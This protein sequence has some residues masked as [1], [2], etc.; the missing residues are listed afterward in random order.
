VPPA[1][2]PE[3]TPVKY[4]GIDVH[5]KMCQAAILDWNGE[6]LDETRFMNTVEGIEEFALK[7][8]A[9]RDEVRA[10]VESTGNLW[11]QVHDRLEEHGHDVALSSP[12]NS[13]L[14]SK[15]RV[16][17]D[18]TDARALAR[19]HR[20]GVLSTCFVPGEEERSRRE[21]LRYRLSPGLCP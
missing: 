16:K 19:L 18:R 15:S 9:Y 5:K 14:V 17:M 4:V 12:A 7:L 2:H 13:R 3:V 8:S 11:I 20:A 1:S 21:L 6:L 10:V